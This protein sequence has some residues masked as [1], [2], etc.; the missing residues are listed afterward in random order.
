MSTL[1]GALR[2]L[3]FP[4]SFLPSFLAQSVRVAQAWRKFKGGVT[5][6]R[7]AK[8]NHHHNRLNFALLHEFVEH[9][10]TC[11]KKKKFSETGECSSRIF[12]QLEWKLRAVVLELTETPN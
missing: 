8:R 12:H 5:R 6:F 7:A 10:W 2:S 4:P 3:S 9:A 11:D 1:N